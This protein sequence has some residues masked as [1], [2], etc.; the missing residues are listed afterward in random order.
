MTKSIYDQL[1]IPE[2][3]R[4]VSVR[5]NQAEFI[6]QFIQKNNLKKTLE[7]GFAY[8]CSA[9][10]IINATKSKH[11]AIDP[12]TEIWGN[13]GFKNLEKLGLKKY[14]TFIKDQSHNALPR[15]LEEGTKL[16]FAFIDGNHFFE[17][18]MVDFHFIDKMLEQDGYIMFDDSWLRATQLVASYIQKNRK[19]Y[20]EIKALPENTI[21]F[22]KI[23][24]DKRIWYHFREFYTL[25]SMISYRRNIW[26]YWRNI[27]R[28]KIQRDKEYHE[29]KF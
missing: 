22:Q 8:G 12:K 20:K 2:R 16:D 17:Y 13:L 27:W 15:L 25:K 23:G 4:Y 6:S 5:K 29:K 14:L 3:F 24:E 26:K 1:E 7:I 28:Y 19:D 10:H 9:A 21:M 11:I 18:I